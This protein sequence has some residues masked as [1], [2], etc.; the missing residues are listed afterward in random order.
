MAWLQKITASED[1][2]PTIFNWSSRRGQRRW[3]HWARVSDRAVPF[4]AAPFRFMTCSLIAE[5]VAQRKTPM[6]DLPPMYTHTHTHTHTVLV[7]FNISIISSSTGYRPSHS[8][9][10]EKK[11]PVLGYSSWESSPTASHPGRRVGSRQF[12]S[13]RR[14]APQI[15]LKVAVSLCS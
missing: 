3:T 1:L 13:T 4:K 10:N 6:L 5:S 14:A 9:K 11:P 15:S 8:E 2:S 12:L 7:N